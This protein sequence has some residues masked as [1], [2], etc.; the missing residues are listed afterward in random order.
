[1]KKF[2][3]SGLAAAMLLMLISCGAAGSGSVQGTDAQK[4][5]DQSGV[6]VETDSQTGGS[7]IPETESAAGTADEQ[8]DT[9]YTTGTPWQDI[10]LEGVVTEDTPTDLKDNFA[11]AANKDKILG[12]T[13]PEGYPY[14]GTI[15]DV[16]LKNSEDL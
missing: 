13:I 1:M 2:I 11:L 10:D 6:T 4:Q 14:G 9:D 16:V 7:R 3:S 15:M 5:E 8:S 12:F